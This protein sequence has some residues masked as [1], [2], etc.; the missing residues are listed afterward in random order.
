MDDCDLYCVMIEFCVSEFNYR[1]FNSNWNCGFD[2]MI[3]KY[4]KSMKISFVGCRL[5]YR[6]KF[7]T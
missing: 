7:L 1:K 5:N 6:S 4:V 3:F 2:V